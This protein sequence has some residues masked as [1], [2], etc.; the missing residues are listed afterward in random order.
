[1]VEPDHR[2]YQNGLRK[3]QTDSRL[4]KNSVPWLFLSAQFKAEVSLEYLSVER[5]PFRQVELQLKHL[6]KLQYFISQPC[7]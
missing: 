5:F 3:L 4:A 2:S 7:P 1:M 6:E